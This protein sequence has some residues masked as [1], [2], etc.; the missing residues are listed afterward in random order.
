MARSDRW[1]AAWALGYVAV[2]GASLLVPV[3]AL[4]LG[5]GAF[6]VGLLAA[7]AAFAGVPAAL[8]VGR[9]GDRPD[10][11]RMLVTVAMLAVA[12]TLGAVPLVGSAA[13]LLV[14]NT[15]LW[16]A[17]AAAAPVCNL[18]VVAD[19]SAATWDD[20]LSRLNAAQGYGWVLGL[21]LGIGWLVLVPDAAAPAQR[22]LALVFA[23]AAALASAG[24]WQ[25]FE[26]TPTTPAADRFVERF[27]RVGRRDL[28]AG[29]IL[30]LNPVGPG[31]LVWSL[32]RLDLGVVRTA[33]AGPLGAFLLGTAAFAVGSAAFWAPMPAY[34][35][36]R[37]LSTT[38]IFLLFLVANVGSAVTYGRVAG[39]E[40]RLGAGRLQL[41]G[42]GVRGVLFPATVV[43]GVA[44]ASVSGLFFLVGVSWAVVAVTAPLLVARLASA[45]RRGAALATYTAV[46]SAGTG[47]GSVGGG[48]VADA[49][50]YRVTFTLAGA[51]VVLGAV[52]A[53][54]GLARV[55]TGGPGAEATSR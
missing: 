18:V 28:G 21:A 44:V 37:G 45:S 8:L 51:S 49:V 36:A 24:L 1:L 33:F 29:R 41:G 13:G 6:V 40:P 16:F 10:R 31:R 5:G 46:M 32:R 38:V 7:T 19:R 34:L 17:V 11:H 48:A 39:L 15:L 55:V 52:V 3:Y 9:L 26:P 47:V 4:T 27:E 25:V 14:L 53:W 12:A 54:W 30:R 22:S 2:G 43:V 35:D 23:V 42:I 50:G 20:R